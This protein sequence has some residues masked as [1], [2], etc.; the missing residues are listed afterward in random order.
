MRASGLAA[1]C[2]CSI[3]SFR[4]FFESAVAA[5]L[6]LLPGAPALAQTSQGPGAIERTIPMPRLESAHPAPTIVAPSL[7]IASADNTAGRFVLGAVNIEGASVFSREDLASAFEPYLATE[8]DEASLKEIAKRITDRYQ[9]AGYLLSYAYVPRQDVRAGIARIVVVEGR[10]QTVVVEGAGRD[11]PALEAIAR[12][13]A[14]GRPLGL[15]A[16]E[17][18]IGLIRDLPGVAVTDTSLSPTSDP[19]SHV[20]KLVVAHD[21]VRQ[22][23]FADNRGPEGSDPARL[24][25]STSLASA[26]MTGDEIRLD[27]FAIPTRRYRY[28]YG[29]A[30][31]TLPIGNGGLRFGLLASAGDLKQRGNGLSIDGDSSNV[32]AQLT[33]P[34]VRSRVWKLVAKGVIND[35]RNSS[36]QDGVRIQRDRLRVARIGLDFAMDTTTRI[37]GDLVVSHGLGVDGRTKVG[38]PLASRPDAG[39]RF[40]KVAFNLQ[41]AHP[42]SKRMALNVAVAAQASDRP[43]LLIEEFALGGNRLGRAYDFNAVTGDRGFGGGVELSYRLPDFRKGPKHVEIFAFADG[44]VVGQKGPSHQAGRNGLASIGAGSRLVFG[45]IAIASE[46]AVPLVSDGRDGSIC[47]LVTV[48]RTF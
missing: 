31:I 42:L 28:L 1:F 36:D 25:S 17:R 47:G 44:G 48:F 35:L 8:I 32:S 46:L 30:G 29:Q 13:L 40:S 24:Y 38:D 27:L 20:L 26:L 16:L 3:S 11:R 45:R 12:R 5:A 39:G 15:G 43:L 2:G 10:V 7:P 22:L 18:T 19:A 14:D 4:A 23:L 21:R 6:M 34:L 37:S 33:Y 9:S 41:L